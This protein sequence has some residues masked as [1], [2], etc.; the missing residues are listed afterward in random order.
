[1]TDITIPEISTQPSQ[2]PKKTNTKIIIIVG[3]VVVLCCLCLV[4]AGVLY[5]MGTKGT[6]PLAMLAT[7]TPTLTNTPTQTPTM[8]T[9][10][11]PGGQHRG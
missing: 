1:M 10:S 6:G 5:Y 3:I 7:D 9:F 11:H 2:N 8:T 4:L